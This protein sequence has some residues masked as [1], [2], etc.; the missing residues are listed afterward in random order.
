MLS[1]GLGAGWGAARGLGRAPDDSK[2]HGM[3]RGALT[4]G[5]SGAG[6]GIGA[7]AGNE[8]SSSVDNPWLRLA[9]IFGSGGLGSYA[10][11]K[12]GDYLADE[13]MGPE[14]DRQDSGVLMGAYGKSSSAG[15]GNSTSDQGIHMEKDAI[16]PGLLASWLGMGLGS[17]GARALYRRFR[18]TGLSP[19]PGVKLTSP[20]ELRAGLGGGLAGIPAGYM[21]GEA[22]Y[23]RFRPKP[24]GN[25]SKWTKLHHLITNPPNLQDIKG[26]GSHMAGSANK[27]MRTL[28]HLPE[29]TGTDKLAY[30]STFLG[31]AG[32]GGPQAGEVREVS[33]HTTGQIG[34][35]TPGSAGPSGYIAE[36]LARAPTDWD[37]MLHKLKARRDPDNREPWLYLRKLAGATNTT[38]ASAAGEYRKPYKVAPD[39]SGREVDLGDVKREKGVDSM[40]TPGGTSESLFVAPDPENQLKK[41]QAPGIRSLASKPGQKQAFDASGL[42]QTNDEAFPP[43]STNPYGWHPT[44]EMIPPHLANDPQFQQNQYDP[45]NEV[46]FPSTW[47][48]KQISHAGQNIPPEAYDLPDDGTDPF[49]SGDISGFKPHTPG[50]QIGGGM[51]GQSPFQTEPSRLWEGRGEPAPEEF[52]QRPDGLLGIPGTETPPDR[53]IQEQMQ[54]QDPFARARADARADEWPAEMMRQE[55]QPIPP[56]GYYQGNWDQDGTGYDRITPGPQVPQMPAPGVQQQQQPPEAPQGPPEP[57]FTPGASSIGMGLPSAGELSQEIPQAP[58][59]QFAG[60]TPG[61]SAVN[62]P[63]SPG[64]DAQQQQ[65]A[66]IAGISPAEMAQRIQRFESGSEHPESAVPP[67]QAGP[68]PQQAPAAPIA[69]QKPAMPPQP[70]VGTVLEQNVPGMGGMQRVQGQGGHEYQPTPGIGAISPGS[71]PIPSPGP[72]PGRYASQIARA[73]QAGNMREV[74]RLQGLEQR[75]PASY[76][77][78]AGTP[79]HQAFTKRYDMFASGQDPNAFNR[80]RGMESHLAGQSAIQSNLAQNLPGAMK[81]RAAKPQP[82]K[83]IKPHEMGAGGQGPQV[84]KVPH[85]QP[86][87]PKMA[88]L[89]K[90]AFK[91]LGGKLLRTGLGYLGGSGAGYGADQIAGLAGYDTGGALSHIGGALGGGSAFLGP[92]RMMQMG[93]TLGGARG[94][95]AAKSLMQ[96]GTMPKSPQA[97]QW[98]KG[99]PLG[100]NISNLGRRAVYQGHRMFNPWASGQ[101]T[102][103]RVFS[104]LAG[105]GLAAE[106]IRGMAESRAQDYVD[107]YAK[108]F[109]YP[110]AQSFINSPAAKMMGMWGNMS[111]GMKAGL[112]G[113]GALG[114]GGLGMMAAGGS[115]GGGLGMMGAGAGLG[116]LG[117]LGGSPSM[118]HYAQQ[119]MANLQNQPGFQNLPP[120]QQQGLMQRILAQLQNGQV[121]GTARG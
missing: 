6:F 25:A 87:A 104:A 47:P 11:G 32:I 105:G 8:L 68:Q 34:V 107:Q 100:K 54:A 65:A 36:K 9:A 119:A 115:T 43:G 81:S 24:Q 88:A 42:P 29:K 46:D 40:L 41:A 35:P 101:N 3:A 98:V 92:R 73:Q 96:M 102:G 76:A 72:K 44:T 30:P 39:Q 77:S 4:G 45:L 18:P 59:Q 63:V 78:Q 49:T 74:R 89:E 85:Q 80:M 16:L 51:G 112:L 67:A 83:V 93:K 21:A 97:L 26:L 90:Q 94:Q 19:I 62:P 86:L 113:G 109:G 20:G 118:Q 15:Q 70:A 64:L 56:E 103:Q 7:M 79:A 71:Q 91:Q 53:P 55:T 61:M 116:A 82:F 57:T 110:D 12:G 66:Q 60:P 22:A 121:G 5:A 120:D 14:R 38:N 58:Q 114:L 33:T 1:L 84:G 31:Q 37:E 17:H 10:A 23:D 111:P 75:T 2:L 28:L 52:D 106:G 48:P 13:L 27:R 99:G 50:T 69:P 117:A 95:G 108:Q